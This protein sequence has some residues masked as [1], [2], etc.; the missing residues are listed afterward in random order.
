[1]KV[2]VN[3]ARLQ[4]VR[5]VAYHKGEQEVP[6]TVANILKRRKALVEPETPVSVPA[7][8]TQKVTS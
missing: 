4:I 2:K 3:V 6:E 1:M 5:G 8:N 7:K